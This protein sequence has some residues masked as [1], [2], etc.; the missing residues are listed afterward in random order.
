VYILEEDVEELKWCHELYHKYNPLIPFGKLLCGIL[1]SL[2]SLM[3]IIHVCIFVLPDD[4][5]SP[6]L[7]E[8][9][10]WFDGW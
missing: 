7:N 3:W 10:V 6:F 1:S 4:P 2:L 9:F 8:Y 5:I